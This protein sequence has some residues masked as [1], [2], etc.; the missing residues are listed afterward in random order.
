LT[1]VIKYLHDKFFAVRRRWLVAI[2]LLLVIFYLAGPS[3]SKPDYSL[4]LP[5]V[6]D[7]KAALEKYIFQNE[8]LH[9][10]K[11]DNQARIV[12]AD[13]STKVITDYSIVYLH[14][15]SASQKEGDPVHRNIA[16]E[17]G[18][19]LYLSRLAEH[20][21]DTTEQLIRFT[22]ENYWESAKQALAIGKKLGRKVILMGCSTG[23]SLALQ[24]AAS[25]PGD[26]AA[27][28]LLSPNIAINDPFAWILNNHWGLQIARMVK[29]GN[30]I[31]SDDDRAIYRMYWNRPYRLESAVELEEYL[32]TTMLKK[33]FGKIKRPVLL[34]YYYKDEIHQDS[35]VRVSAMLNMFDQLETPQNL[36]TRKAMPNTGDHVICSPIKSHDVYGVQKEI[37]NFF[38]DV[39]GMNDKKYQVESALKT[40]DHL[41]LKMDAD[42]IA[43]L[44]MPKGS[45]GNIVRGRDSIRYFLQQFKNM[46]VLYQSSLSDSI[47]IDHGTAF[48][49]GSYHQTVVVSAFDTVHVKGSFNAVW[50]RFNNNWLIQH[51]ETSPV[52]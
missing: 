11:P 32:E 34:L 42:S 13:D 28:I 7:N 36:K 39:L 43:L 8:S 47:S 19:N 26:V 41:I 40:Y 50:I 46:K 45:L 35:V 3:P 51:M 24:L 22:A 10:L 30:Y 1:N 14:G 25:F 15:F 23:G 21:I 37:E 9:K 27:L 38:T 33:N 4:N 52:K 17:F 49:K 48:Q 44:Y 20:G 31:V 12:W 5:T 6:P 18:C 2:L 29:H 16:R